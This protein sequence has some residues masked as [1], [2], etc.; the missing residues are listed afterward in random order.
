M[1]EPVNPLDEMLEG[2]PMSQNLMTGDAE[3]GTAQRRDV[4]EI[5]QDDQEK[6]KRQEN[7]FY[8]Q[9]LRG[10]NLSWVNSG[11]INVS[12]GSLG[13]EGELFEVKDQIQIPIDVS[14]TSGSLFVFLAVK[15]DDRTKIKGYVSKDKV[16]ANVP[17]GFRKLRR[18]GLVLTD[19]A[20]DVEA[21]VQCG[22][23]WQ[24]RYTLK[25]SVLLDDT[26][27]VAM[28]LLDGSALPDGICSFR[29]QCV[30]DSGAGNQNLDF[31]AA[32]E[33]VDGEAAPTAVTGNQV[34]AVFGKIIT[35]EFDMERAPGLGIWFSS[36]ALG[37]TTDELNLRG[38]TDDL[39]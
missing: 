21:F 14:V 30:Y 37:A 11:A 22:E 23:Y 36:S 39:S 6:T 3:D 5:T 16:G 28:R 7:L 19:S 27:T 8:P 10:L 26:F 9:Q 15:N 32:P 38:Y 29:F 2:G 17:S 24:K 31:H 13:I 25:D 35:F 33:M 20:N 18:I 12:S 4:Q 1:V 34:F